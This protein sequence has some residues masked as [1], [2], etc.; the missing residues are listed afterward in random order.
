[1][2]SGIFF[3]QNKP[4]QSLKY[5]YTNVDFHV[6]STWHPPTEICL[7]TWYEKSVIFSTLLC[8]F[9]SRSSTFSWRTLHFHHSRSIADL[10]VTLLIYHVSSFDI[11][12]IIQY[13]HCFPVTNASRIFLPRWLNVD[14]YNLAHNVHWFHNVHFHA[15]TINCTFPS[16]NFLRKICHGLRYENW[17]IRVQYCS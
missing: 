17:I 10:S 5:T 2:F 13:C 11:I 9:P 8:N 1:M 4:W 7:P 12:Y 15:I 16:M 14:L 6:T 3:Q